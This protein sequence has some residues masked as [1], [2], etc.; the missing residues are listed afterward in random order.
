VI[1]RRKFIYDLWGD[2]VNTASRMESHGVAGS[3]QVTPRVFEKL[4]ERYKFAAREPMLIKGKGMMAP[5][6]LVG[7]TAGS[8][9]SVLLNEERRAQP[10]P[11]T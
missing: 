1:G 6:L 4:K 8:A 7:K 5:Y 3:I 10:V 2:T 11:Q 9:A